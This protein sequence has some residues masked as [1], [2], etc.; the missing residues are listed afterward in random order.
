MERF[1]KKT[2]DLLEFLYKDEISN[3]KEIFYSLIEQWRPYRHFKDLRLTENDVVLI[4]Y[5]DSITGEHEKPLRTLKRFL[6]H[7]C[8][9]VI[10]N[11]HLLP[12]FPST[13]DDGFSVSD[14]RK[15]DRRLGDWEDVEALSRDYGLMLDAVVNH[16]SQAHRWF[17]S[18][19]EGDK[20]YRD[21]YIEANPELDYSMVTR[22][23]TLPLLTPF[24]TN[25]GKKHYWT[26]FSPDQVDLNYS[27]P[28]VLAEMIEILLFYASKGAKFIRLDA[29]GFVYKKLGG[30]CVHL[31]ET[32]AIVKLI[33]LFFDYFFP[34]VYLITE[35]NVPHADNISYFGNSDEAH[36]IYQFPLPP[37]T[38]FALQS[39][40]ATKLTKWAQSLE[41]TPL[42]RNNTYFNFLA[43]HDGVGIRPLEGILN[44]EEKRFL[45]DNVIRNGGRISYYANKD[46]SMSPYELNISYIDGITNPAKDKAERVK[47]FMAAQAVILSMQGVPG[48]YY[49][50]LLGS[51]NWYAGVNST[52]I[53][54]KI[55]REKLDYETLTGELKDKSSLRYQVFT[56]YQEILKIRA[57]HSAFSPY[58]GQR[59]LNLSPSLFVVERANDITKE[60]VIAII[61]V[62]NKTVNLDH[63]IQGTDLLAKSPNERVITKIEPYQ[64]AWILV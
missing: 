35:T 44:D 43:S 13:S 42:K 49:H 37:L 30:N 25:E 59:V 64:I 3:A 50:S 22:P 39:G 2:F 9:Q 61:N 54:R 46:G 17:Q 36:L 5:G 21:Y 38:M 23:R 1:I 48:I 33:R 28:K 18:C 14:Y 56:A 58:A 24:Q 8:R 6:D 10:S 34:G 19:L 45:F 57:K 52:G 60:R 12:I 40:D 53:N 62:T 26:T 7:Y 32:H 27:N 41:S 29:I 20:E 15:I 31:P 4:A 11:I 51:E 55:N 47:R 63:P 16:S